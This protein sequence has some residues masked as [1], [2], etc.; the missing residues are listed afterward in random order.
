MQAELF[1]HIALAYATDYGPYR[2]QHNL[3][4]TKRVSRDTWLQTFGQSAR[5]SVS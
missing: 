2:P 4:A 1:A 3:P 5:G